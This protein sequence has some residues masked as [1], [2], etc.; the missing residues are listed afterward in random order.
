MEDGRLMDD[1]SIF[2]QIYN[3]FIYRIKIEQ[4]SSSQTVTWPEDTWWFIPLRKKGYNPSCK[5]TNP[6]SP[7][8]HQG[9]NPLIE[10]D[11][12]PSSK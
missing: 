2:C 7:V 3:I 1:L 4:S 5:W 9:Y 11:E 10:W 6:T 8:Y 12:P